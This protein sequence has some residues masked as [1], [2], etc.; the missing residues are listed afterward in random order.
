MPRTFYLNL[1]ELVEAISQCRDSGCAAHRR[2]SGASTR[3]AS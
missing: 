1:P 2:V 3:T